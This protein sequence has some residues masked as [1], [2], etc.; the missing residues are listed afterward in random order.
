MI[1][2]LGLG[3]MLE[4]ADYVDETMAKYPI[5]WSNPENKKMQEFVDKIVVESITGIHD[6]LKQDENSPERRAL[7]DQAKATSR[8]ILANP[9]KGTG[10]ALRER[11]DFVKQH[12]NP[13]VNPTT[14]KPIGQQPPP[15]TSDQQGSAVKK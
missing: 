1:N 10:I 6:V 8:E 2:D 11:S 13:S 12:A 9:S 5:D 14:V 3:P 15:L 7:I 4:A